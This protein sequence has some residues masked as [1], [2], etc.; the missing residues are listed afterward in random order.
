MIT[1]H[2]YDT[3]VHT[4]ET[5]PC[6]KLHAAETVEWYASH[7]YTGL[8]ITDHLHK[9]FLDTAGADHGWD[10][11]ID[12]YCQGYRAALQK[13]NEIGFTVIFGAEMRFEDNDNDYLIYGID[14]NWLRQHP[15]VICQSA[16]DFF[17][18]YHNDV[19]IIQAHPY[20]DGNINVFEDSIHGIEL[21]NTNRRHNNYPDRALDLCKKHPEYFRQ[22]GSDTHRAEDRCLAGIET[23]QN[24]HNSFEFADL[25]RSGN[26][27]LYAPDFP[28][29]VEED[30]QLRE[31][32]SDNSK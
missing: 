18:K 27:C 14:E 15:Y 28:Q 20:R 11:L 32:K 17:Q 12:K 7:G 26:Y 29:Y 8:V 23:E 31:V 24:I 3:H 30:R 10:I 25:I 22:A 5:S 2:L 4:I 21:I 1:K 13:G 19:L 9:Q 6:G 16:R